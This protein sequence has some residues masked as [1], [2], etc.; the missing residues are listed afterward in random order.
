MIDHKQGLYFFE[1]AITPNTFWVDLKKMDFSKTTGVVR[2]LDLGPN[3]STIYSGEVSSQFKIA[4]AFKF[5][6]A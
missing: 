3:Q 1:S 5:E 6:G 4:P 2:K